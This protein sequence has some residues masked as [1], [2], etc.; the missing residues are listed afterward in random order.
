MESP[1]K[2]SKKA[3]KALQAE[4]ARSGKLSAPSPDVHPSPPPAAATQ[5]GKR[6][7][8]ELDTSPLQ[9][10][11]FKRYKAE[12]E[13]VRRRNKLL[14][15]MQAQVL[16]LESKLYMASKSELCL[17]EDN[18]GLKAHISALSSGLGTLDSRCQ[19]P[20]RARRKGPHRR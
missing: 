13:T 2:L 20:Y 8:S 3:M 16:D 11:T 14:E 17:S 19:E 5:R 6:P 7:I 15:T 18:E 4:R 9:T 1:A 12:H 10:H